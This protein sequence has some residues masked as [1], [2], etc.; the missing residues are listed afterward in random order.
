MAIA[1]TNTVGAGVTTTDHDNIFAV[2]TQ[3]SLDL[4]TRVDLVLLGQEFHGEMNTVQVTPW[5]WQVTRLFGSASQHD[6][7]KI[8]LQLG[9]RNGHFGP[10]GDFAA[11]GQFANHYTSPKNDALGLHLCDTPVDV[12]LFHL[13]VRNAITQQATNTIV[14][15]EQSHVMPRAGKLLRRRHSGRARADNSH[16]FSGFCLRRLRMHPTLVPGAVDDGVLN[17]LDAYRVVIHIQRTGGFAGRWT[18]ATRELGKIIG[19]VQNINGI[20]PVA[21]V[22]QVVEVRNDV[23]DRAATVTK[24]RTAVHATGGLLV[25]LG[26]VKPNDKLFVILESFGDWLVA[27]FDPLKL[28]KTGHLSHGRIL[29]SL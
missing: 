13:E 24:R 26:V 1:G 8:L 18:N 14:L 9:G 11:L 7:V 16:F 28:Y 6:S 5:H 10:V 17:R 29:F 4:V 19:A 2:S 25:G 3:L 12:G 22:N 23:V 15:L 20:L 21:P 27:L